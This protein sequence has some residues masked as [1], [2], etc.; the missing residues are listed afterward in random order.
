MGLTAQEGGLLINDAVAKEVHSDLDHRSTGALPITSLQEPQL[1]VLYGE[2]HVLHVLVVGFEAL[3]KHIEL[4]IDL[5]HGFFHRWVEAGT[6]LF[7]D[8]LLVCPVERA[9]LCDLLWCT[10]PS[11]YVFALSVDEVFAVEDIFTGTCISAKANT[12]S[13]GVSHV[14]EYHSLDVDSCPPFSRDTFHLAIEDSALVH[15]AIED[16]ADSTPELLHRISGEVLACAALDLLLEEYDEALE[17]VDIQ[18]IIQADATLSFDSV[19][20]FFE[21]GD[22]FLCL[23]LHTEDDVTI[24]LHEAAVAI[25]GEAGIA[26]LLRKAFDDGVIEPK[27]EDGVHHTRHGGASTRADRYKEWVGGIAKGRSHEAFDM[28]HSAHHFV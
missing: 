14:A 2:L 3:L 21:G 7:A 5:G 13:R 17:F 9:S 24:H 1:A 19:D 23:G 15:P 6:H 27:V 18:L 16:G 8:A 10:D 12:R 22:I 26:C 25:V 20:D 4:G 28:M 11:Y